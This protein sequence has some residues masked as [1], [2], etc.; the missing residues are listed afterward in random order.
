MTFKLYTTLTYAF[1]F[2]LFFVFCSLFL[3]IHFRCRSSCHRTWPRW[4]W[5]AFCTWA[6]WLACGRVRPAASHRL[7][8]G[9]LRWLYT[10][11]AHTPRVRVNNN[12]GG[13]KKPNLLNFGGLELELEFW[14]CGHLVRLFVRLFAYM[15]HSGTTIHTHAGLAAAPAPCGMMNA[16]LLRL[17]I[18]QSAELC[19]RC[20]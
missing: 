9:E 3:C 1:F 2:F 5:F 14:A 17:G 13:K 11:I 16:L 19:G 20:S 10:N 18:P 12:G 7:N 6:C 8:R 4:R 15:T